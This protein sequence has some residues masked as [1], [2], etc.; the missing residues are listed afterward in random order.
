MIETLPSKTNPFAP[1]L[2][3]VKRV[4]TVMVVELPSKYFRLKSLA[5]SVK[6]LVSQFTG[7]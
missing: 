3:F 4:E 2:K 7:M 6:G 1:S 5:L